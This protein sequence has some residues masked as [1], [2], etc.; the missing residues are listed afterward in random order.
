MLFVVQKLVQQMRALT[1]CVSF[2]LNSFATANVG[3]RNTMSRP[4]VLYPI[5]NVRFQ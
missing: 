2:I 1:V 4:A 3:Q 5:Q